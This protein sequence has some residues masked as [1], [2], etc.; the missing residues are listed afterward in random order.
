M[1]FFYYSFYGGQGLISGAID[2]IFGFTALF[3]PELMMTS[4]RGKLVI[5][6]DDILLGQMNYTIQSFG[7]LQV[8]VGIISFIFPN[9]YWPLIT[10]ALIFNEI[11][12]YATMSQIIDTLG[13]FISS[14]NVLFAFFR[15]LVVGVGVKEVI[16]SPGYEWYELL[17][18]WDWWKILS[19]SAGIFMFSVGNKFFD[20]LR[21]ILSK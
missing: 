15:F 10:Q 11:V 8:I 14:M 2:I 1:Y 21:E 5:D 9:G 20:N 16:G 4:R 13:I 3:D 19:W 6:L 7:I 18:L 17:N 12:D